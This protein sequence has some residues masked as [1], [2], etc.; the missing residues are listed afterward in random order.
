MKLRL[1]AELI[2]YYCSVIQKVSEIKLKYSEK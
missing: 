2:G 1:V